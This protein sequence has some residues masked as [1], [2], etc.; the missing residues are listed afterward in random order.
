MQVAKQIS[1]SAKLIPDET[2]ITRGLGVMTP[3][4]GLY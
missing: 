3:T 2:F 1:S 4:N